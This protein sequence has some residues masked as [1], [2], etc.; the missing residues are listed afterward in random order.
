MNMNWIGATQIWHTF[1]SKVK[2]EAS[3]DSNRASNV[4]FSQLFWWIKAGF[5]YPIRRSSLGHLVALEM[6]TE[7][8]ITRISKV[9][10]SQSLGNFDLVL[11]PD[12]D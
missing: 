3:D 4:S 12:G 5:S 10:N 9:H 8:P 7:I 11:L 2:L 6:I 1:R